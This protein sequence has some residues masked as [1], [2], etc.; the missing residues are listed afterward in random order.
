MKLVKGPEAER[1]TGGLWR[2]FLISEIAGE[3]MLGEVQ[4]HLYVEDLDFKGRS[5]DKV[6]RDS[7]ETGFLDLIDDATERL[8]FYKKELEPYSDITEL[9]SEK[10]LKRA[11]FHMISGHTHCFSSSVITDNPYYQ[12]IKIP[13]VEKIIS[14]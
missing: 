12:C 2:Q 4:D 11:L 9:L 10:E 14:F 3:I 8:S 7:V 5:K 13:T 1:V 6:V